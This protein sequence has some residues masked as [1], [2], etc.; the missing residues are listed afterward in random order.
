MSEQTVC[1]VGLGLMGGSLGLALK[2]REGVRVQAYARR[3]DTRA[4][5]MEMGAADAVF[6]DIHDAVKGAGLVVFCTPVRC[7]PDL[8]SSVKTDLDSGC[9]VTD[10]GST[11]AELES[12]INELPI[13][14]SVT[15]VGSHPI[16]GSEKDGLESAISD[17]YEGAVTVVTGDGSA[18]QACVT[19]MWTSIGSTVKVLTAAEHD[20]ALA[21]TSHL[22]HVLA[23]LLVDVVAG[24]SSDLGAVC[25]SGFR[26]VSRLASGP[27]DVWTDILLSN[28]DAVSGSLRSIRERLDVVLTAIEAGDGEAVQA[29]LAAAR[30]SRS[31]LLGADDE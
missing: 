14:G 20:Q 28:A 2:R 19:A 9:V 10:V 7:I 17:L 29:F 24:G 5:A 30:Q 8:L 18:A 12:S 4:L 16:C 1:I 13:D 23:S 22:P 26:D 15:Y 25:G 6:E 11:K 3:S 21:L 27:A 31:E